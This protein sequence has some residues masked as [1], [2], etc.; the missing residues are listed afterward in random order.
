[1][2]KRTDKKCET[3]NCGII[4]ILF[5]V[6]MLVIAI[7]MTGFYYPQY[8]FF[9]ALAFQNVT[10]GLF[11]VIFVGAFITWVDKARQINK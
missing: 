6:M 8:S 2:V 7:F 1:M 10:F 5:L 9:S 11:L 4:K 3:E